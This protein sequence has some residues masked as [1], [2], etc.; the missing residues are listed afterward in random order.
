MTIQQ[1]QRPFYFLT[2]LGDYPVHRD[3][4]T[5]TSALYPFLVEEGFNIGN[6]SVIAG[7]LSTGYTYDNLDNLLVANPS[8]LSG[9]LLRVAVNYTYD[10]SDNL[11]VSNPSILSGTLL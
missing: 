11:L 1:T 4:V 7:S 2:I 10:N 9:T 6:P 3:Y 5:F 8:I